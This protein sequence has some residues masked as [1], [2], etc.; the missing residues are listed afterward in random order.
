MFFLNKDKNAH[1][2]NLL[3]IIFQYVR[4]TSEM[5]D[6]ID[7]FIKKVEQ[8]GLNLG[9]DIAFEG[10]MSAIR[11]EYIVKKSSLLYKLFHKIKDDSMYPKIEEELKQ[12]LKFLHANVTDVIV[13]EYAM[14]LT[15]MLDYNPL[16][17]RDVYKDEMKPLKKEEECN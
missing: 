14:H 1:I 4:L 15:A 10:K 12:K 16:A 8:E 11:L 9:D 17:F 13:G 6:S 2:T 7:D 5:Q 3:A